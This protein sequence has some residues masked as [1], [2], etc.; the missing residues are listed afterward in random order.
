MDQRGEWISAHAPPDEGY[1]EALLRDGEHGPAA[2]T[3][4]PWDGE[5]ED[6]FLEAVESSANAQL[7]DQTRW[8]HARRALEQGEVLTLAI[9]GYNRGG[10]LVAWNGLEGFIPTS[11]LVSLDASSNEQERHEILRNLVGHQLHLKVIEVEPEQERF[12]LSERAIQH[13]KACRQ[14]VLDS[15]CPGD[16]RTG[17]VTSLCSFGAF[18]D[19]GG[20]EGLIHVSELG[21]GR[22]EHPQ[23]VL[24]TNQMVDVYVLNV[25]REQERVGLSIKRLLPDPWQSVEERYRAGQ[26]VEGIITHVVNFGA[27]AQIEEGLEG[28]I[29]VSELEEG[30]IHH[31]RDVVREGDRVT[32]RVLNVDGQRRRLGLSLRQV[33]RVNQSEIPND[34]T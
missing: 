20:I 24:E 7:D 31:P 10:A 8:E 33:R 3:I 23:D 18:I 15:I 17:R 12:V 30:P 4:A 6:V 32:A 22:I 11:H 19:L 25:D 27:F 29:H 13:D 14:E 5:Q 34:Q 28:L 9:V 1:W 2:P 16:V 21:W 26:I